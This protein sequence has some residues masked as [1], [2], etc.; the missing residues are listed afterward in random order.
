MDLDYFNDS[1]FTGQA[2]QVT[3][4]VQETNPVKII[5]QQLNTVLYSSNLTID[6][7][8][9]NATTQ[10]IRVFQQVCGLKNRWHLGTTM[11]KCNT[12]DLWKRFMRQT[13]YS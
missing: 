9:G 5:Q 13:L 12:T 1:I 11:C 6:G 7:I 2:P 3:T 8:Q 4:A 10:Q